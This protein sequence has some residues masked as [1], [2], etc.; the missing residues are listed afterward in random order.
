MGLLIFKKFIIIFILLFLFL[1]DV[2][3]LLKGFNDFSKQKI[4]FRKQ[5]KLKICNSTLWYS[6]SISIHSCL[7][8]K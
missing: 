7:I 3:E 4:T 8:K 1:R 2:Y 6:M 5:R